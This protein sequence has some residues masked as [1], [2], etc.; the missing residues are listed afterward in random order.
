MLTHKISYSSIKDTVTYWF[1]EYINQEGYNVSQTSGKILEEEWREVNCSTFTKAS[2]ILNIAI[3]SLKRGQIA[4]FIIEKIEQI[5]L[6]DIESDLYDGKVMYEQDLIVF[7]QLK[8][9]KKYEVIN[10]TST[11]KARIDYI[12]GLKSTQMRR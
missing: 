4:D 2:Y 9:L 11:S 3:E 1:E 6:E 7:K 5:V 8:D 10:N 12:L